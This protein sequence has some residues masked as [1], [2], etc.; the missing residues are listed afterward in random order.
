MRVSIA[1]EG[2]PTMDGRLIA[3]GALQFPESPIPVSLWATGKIVGKAYDF[4]READGL[5][6]AEVEVPEG[7]S[8]SYSISADQPELDGTTVKSARIRALAAET[9]W[10]WKEEA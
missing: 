3:H 9:D 4:R 1:I 5:I 8:G 2:T 10:N 7:V 6:T